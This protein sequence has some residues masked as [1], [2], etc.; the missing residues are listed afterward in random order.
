MHLGSNFPSH[1][2]SNLVCS[3]ATAVPLSPCQLRQRLQATTTSWHACKSVLLKVCGPAGIIANQALDPLDTTNSLSDLTRSLYSPPTPALP[4]SS[5][6]TQSPAADS[7]QHGPLVQMMHSIVNRSGSSSAQAADKAQEGAHKRP[8]GSDSGS[9]GLVDL[10]GGAAS[11]TDVGSDGAAVAEA[12]GAGSQA[13]NA[14]K[15]QAPVEDYYRLWFTWSD[16]AKAG[17]TSLGKAEEAVPESTPGADTAD[18]TRL[19]ASVGAD[20]SDGGESDVPISRDSLGALKQQQQQEQQ[21]SVIGALEQQ[22]ELSATN[23]LEQQQEEQLSVADA[24]KQ[25]QEQQLSG[26][27]AKKQQQEQQLSVTDALEQEQQL[28]GGDANKHQLPVEDYYRLW[29]SWNNASAET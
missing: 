5:A 20:R 16:A 23:A 13:A 28:S 8:N 1:L 3:L 18:A 7:T 19:S 29:F 17:S 4:Q 15:Q 21:L 27:D 9:S 22:Q 2:I 25:Q 14:V 24:K 11:Q 26:G 12:A 6:P 10:G